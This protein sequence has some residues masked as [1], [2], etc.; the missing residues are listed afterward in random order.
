MI[1][2]QLPT[3]LQSINSIKH[4]DPQIDCRLECGLLKLEWWKIGLHLRVVRRTA[5]VYLFCN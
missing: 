2:H 5:P 3:V 4:L 1:L